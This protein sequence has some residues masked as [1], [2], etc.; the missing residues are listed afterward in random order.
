MT[1]EEHAAIWNQAADVVSAMDPRNGW[2]QQAA[3]HQQGGWVGRSYS[4]KEA[5]AWDGFSNAARVLR[6]IATGYSAEAKDK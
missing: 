1:K 6:Q 5:A 2:L 4:E 3:Q